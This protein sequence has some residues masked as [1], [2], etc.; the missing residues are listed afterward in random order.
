MHCL[1]S[2]TNESLVYCLFTEV[3]L[4]KNYYIEKEICMFH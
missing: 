3:Y 1:K 4:K 2:N